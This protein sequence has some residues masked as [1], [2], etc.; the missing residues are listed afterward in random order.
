MIFRIDPRF[1]S[2][3]SSL[4]SKNADAADPWIQPADPRGFVFFWPNRRSDSFPLL[5]MFH[6]FT[7][8][9]KVLF[10][11]PNPPRIN[12]FTGSQTLGSSRTLLHR[13]CLTSPYWSFQLLIYSFHEFF[14]YIS[15]LVTIQRTW[16][17]KNNPHHFFIKQMLSKNVF[18]AISWCF[19]FGPAG[20]GDWTSDLPT[21]KSPH[22]SAPT[23]IRHIYLPKSLPQKNP[24]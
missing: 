10:H 2:T 5:L 14:P 9:T 18:S 12:G 1:S 17:I 4:K 23:T 13:V 16:G 19:F 21:F 22:C 24:T 6:D 3:W 11:Q 8:K 7:Q 15:I 20:A